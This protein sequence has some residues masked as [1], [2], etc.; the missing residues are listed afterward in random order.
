MFVT[1]TTDKTRLILADR[2]AQSVHLPLRSFANFPELGMRS[3]APRQN[4]EGALDL[5][6]RS[7]CGHP[8]GPGTGEVTP[9]QGLA[10]LLQA[11][12][13]KVDDIKKTIVVLVRTGTP[14]PTTSL[15]VNRAPQ[16][17]HAPQPLQH[18]YHPSMHAECIR[19]PSMVH[20]LPRPYLP[21]TGSDVQNNEHRST[22]APTTYIATTGVESSTS[23]AGTT[24]CW[25]GGWGAPAPTPSESSSSY[26]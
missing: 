16:Y 17:K 22:A 4:V 9:L 3:P 8:R 10:R 24:T 7:Q 15:N 26:Y 12:S 20:F 21:I 13:P 23:D 19:S 6:L 25:D 2:P 14:S 5:P 11:H 1:P 18:R